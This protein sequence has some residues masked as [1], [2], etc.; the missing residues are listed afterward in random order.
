MTVVINDLTRQPRRWTAFDAR[1]SAGFLAIPLEAIRQHGQAAQTL[2]GLID[3]LRRDGRYT[4]RRQ[5]EIAKA[6]GVSVRTL[7]RHLDK[8][9]AAGLVRSKATPTTTLYK[10]AV[11]ESQLMAA[12]FVPVP[13]YVLSRPWCERILYGWIVYRA[14]LSGDG[15]TCWDGLGAIGKA[16]GADRRVL[17]RAVDGLVAAGLMA[18]DANL[19][20]ER[21]LFTLLVPSSQSGDDN[22]SAPHQGDDNLAE[23]VVTIC[24]G[25]GDN[26]ADSIPIKKRSKNT[27]GPR[28][29]TDHFCFSVSDLTATA[30]ELFRRC[31]YA[32]EDGRNLWKL[33]GL[34]VAGRI[35]EAEL[36]DSAQGAR[37]CAARDRPAYVF[38][39]VQDHLRRR[40]VDL[41]DELRKVRIQ[42]TWPSGPPPDRT[43]EA[44][45]NL[46]A[47]NC[48]GG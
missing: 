5:S 27:S 6:A 11:D 44:I 8:L 9:I 7:R 30:G 26:L 14:E 24:P 42:P 16:L 20:G 35:S 46:L 43:A 2:A 45:A 32:G 33:A 36:W 23:Q 15:S 19:E 41:T 28:R 34:L 22:L 1:R 47:K 12:G 3:V 4:F 40:G 39:I 37:E 13:R 10:L 18:R 25:G 29:S 31:G 17:W 48:P 38:A 21:G